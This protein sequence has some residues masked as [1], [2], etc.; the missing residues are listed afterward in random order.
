LASGTFLAAKVALR[1]MGPLQLAFLRFLIAA[2]ILW[3]L[4]ER[5]R[6]GRI[7]ERRDQWTL[8]GLGFLA[9]PINQG[10]FLYGL[11]WTTTGHSA[12]LYCA[13]PLLVMVIAARQ[14][15]EPITMG[16]T[17]GIV[18]AFGGVILVLL[19]RGLNFAPG[20][21][22][23]DILVLIAVVAWAYFTVLGKPLIK[24]Y[25]AVVVTA[26]AMMYGTVLFLPVGLLT[27]RGFSPAAVSPHAWL[28]L[29]YCAIVTSVIA[30]TLWYWALN[31]IDAARVAVFN[32][33]QPVVAAFV[34]W[35]L[36]GET[37][38]LM[39]IGGGLLVVI[40]VLLTEK[41]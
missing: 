30:Y 19:E 2:A 4:G 33:I 23:G 5:Y 39:F 15:G 12:L 17:I 10:F 7:I 1:D 16:R 26:R 14:L 35:S 21:F 22:T 34:G 3:P 8:W 36:L 29:L 38:S 31:Y 37:I 6:R 9:I 32:N 27:V 20:Q 28:G 18:V 40:G 41:L 11:Q 13:T 25:G 24:K